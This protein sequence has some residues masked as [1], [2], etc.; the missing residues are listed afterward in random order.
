VRKVTRKVNEFKICEIEEDH[1]V[2]IHKGIGGGKL[3][4]YWEN[5]WQDLAIFPDFLSKLETY[6]KVNQFQ[7]IYVVFRKKNLVCNLIINAEAVY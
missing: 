6:Q 4:P 2:V 1:D 3:S 5:K 7:G